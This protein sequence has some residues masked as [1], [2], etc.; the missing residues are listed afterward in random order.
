MTYADVQLYID[1]GWRSGT[2]PAI[3]VINP[4]TEAVLGHVACASEQDLDDAVGAATRGFAAWRK[5]PALQRS[6]KLRRIADLLRE[7]RDEIARVLTL[8][9]GKPL[10]QSRLEIGNSADIFDWFAEE[11]RRTYGRIIPAR[12]SDVLQ[13]VVKEPVGPVAAFTPWNFPMNQTTRKVAAALAAGCSVIVKASEE[14][15]GS[16]AMLFQAMEDADLPK[17]AVNL[18][19]GIPS[20][21]SAYLIARPE[22]RKISFTG[23]TAVGKTLAEMAGRHMKRITMELG[24]HA[25]VIVFDDVDL[26]RT[27]DLLAGAKFRNSGQVCIAPTRFLVQD[28]IYEAFVD[29]FV[30]SAE[31]V[32]VG[33]GLDP[34]TTMGPL[35]SE[36]RRVAVDELVEDALQ[37]GAQM[38]TG[39]RHPA[40]TGYFYKPTVLTDVPQAARMLNDEPFGPIAIMSSFSTMAEAIAEANR[41]PYGLASYAYTA[42]SSRAAQVSGEIE[43]GMISINHHGLGLIETP[44]GGVKDSG[45]GSE[46]GLEAIES[47]L[48]TKTVSHYVGPDV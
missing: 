45:Y 9:Q 22:I 8:E 21:I 30:T 44:F 16:V 5:V 13:S 2:R 32:V 40:N 29:R 15:P 11:A 3:P 37:R 4:A 1:G 35:V 47:Y 26:D 23:S 39:G 19:Y 38:R 48:V 36:R 18:V 10:A 33:D 43:T 27:A 41:L 7:R 46:G 12:S 14:T 25:P 20:E 6:Q 31:Q 17:G 24:G 42:S 34:A 28:G